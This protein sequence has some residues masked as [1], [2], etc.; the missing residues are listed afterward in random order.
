MNKCNRFM[1]IDV[2]DDD[3]DDSLMIVWMVKSE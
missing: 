3:D 1:K 2:D